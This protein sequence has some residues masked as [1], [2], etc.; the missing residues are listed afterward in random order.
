M[1]LWTCPRLQELVLTREWTTAGLRLPSKIATCGTLHLR[2]CREKGRTVS[3]A[4]HLSEL[5]IALDPNHPSHVVP[6]SLSPSKCVLDI[7]CG[8]G[9]TLIAVYPDRVSFGLDIDMRALKLGRTLTDQVRFACGTADAL[10]YQ[11]GSFDMVVARVS[12][13]YVNLPA[14]FREI[15]RVLRKGGE[16]WITLH[17][18]SVVWKY[19]KGH[20][21]RTWISF[22]YILLNSLLFH[23]V[24]KQFSVRGRCESFQTKRGLYRA[25]RKGG[26]DDIS[27]SK[28]KERIIVT[29]RLL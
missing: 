15:R 6:P 19:T 13:P 26:F 1:W 25:L 3:D 7:G 16:L 28:N 4:Y 24:Q 29:A 14:A 17:P 8:A 23:F 22:G 5:N 11:N 10:P 12:L 2:S 21:F 27:I 9:Q 18:F 20:N